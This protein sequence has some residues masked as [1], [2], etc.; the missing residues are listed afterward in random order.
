MEYGI[1][2]RDYGRASLALRVRYLQCGIR[3]KEAINYGLFTDCST[4]ITSHEDTTFI[5]YRTRPMTGTKLK[6]S[7]NHYSAILK[8]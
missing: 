6:L 5:I 3:G 4:I 1:I 7:N 8:K 2:P